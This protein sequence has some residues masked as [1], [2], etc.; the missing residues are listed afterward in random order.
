MV[1]LQAAW[2]YLTKG[3]QGY[4]VVMRAAR[5][6]SLTNPWAALATV[7]TVVGVAVY[8]CYKYIVNYNKALHDNL[9]SVKNAK[10]V[11]ESQANLA[12]KVSEATLDERNKIDM[13]NKVIHS[14]AYTV[15]ERRL[16]IA[17][18]QKLVPEYHASISKEG[19]L[20][21]DNQIAIQNYIKEL[22]N[23]AMAEAIY[24]RKVEINK[25]RLT[26][27]QRRDAYVVLSK[28]W[29][30]SVKLTRRNTK[31]RLWLML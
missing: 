12:K 18:M 7:L 28:L 27:K 17:N 9:Q 31:V 13:L 30:P 15:D 16:A 8:G 5:L 11:A 6:A 29:M 1:A 2:A 24:E 25:K 4:I 14:N 10:A 3:V 23:A 19:K 26:L 20:Y 22:E 21:N